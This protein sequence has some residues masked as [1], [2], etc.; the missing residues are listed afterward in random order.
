M[1]SVVMVIVLPLGVA[2]VMLGV[3]AESKLKEH[4]LVAQDVDDEDPAVASVACGTV[5]VQ[6]RVRTTSVDVIAVKETKSDPQEPKAMV[7]DLEKP[8]PTIETSVPPAV[9]PVR[10]ET[11]SNFNFIV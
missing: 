3:D 8:E 5:S 6:A 11:E 7:V 9:L 2:P 4:V 10:G 1:F